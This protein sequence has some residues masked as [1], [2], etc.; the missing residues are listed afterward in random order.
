V[1]QAVSTIDRRIGAL[2]HIGEAAPI[3]DALVATMYRRRR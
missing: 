1:R 2:R 3:L